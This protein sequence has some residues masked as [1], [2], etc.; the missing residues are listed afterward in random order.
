[1]TNLNDLAPIHR[2]HSAAKTVIA[3]LLDAS[4][5][6]DHN[7]VLLRYHSLNGV[8]VHGCIVVGIY[9]TRLC[10]SFGA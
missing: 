5:I 4:M 6:L 10:S 3:M 7:N 2:Q 8:V 9:G 1:M